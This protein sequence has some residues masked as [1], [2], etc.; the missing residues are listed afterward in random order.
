M[1]QD[2]W[3]IPSGAKNVQ[4]AMTFINW[5]M[6]P[7]NSLRAVEYNNYNSYIDGVEELMPDDLK[8]DSAIITPSDVKLMDVP[9]CSTDVVNKYSQIWEQFKE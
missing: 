5:M 2:N 3:S 7:E 8:N 6:K 4:Q 9:Q 1:Y